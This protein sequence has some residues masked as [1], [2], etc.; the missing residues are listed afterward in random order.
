MLEL[1]NKLKVL[2][3]NN[4]L[5]QAYMANLL[6]IT[7]R[8]YQDIEYG[9]IDL[10]LSK[11]IKLADFFNVSLDYLVG[12]SNEEAVK[13]SPEYISKLPAQT[14]NQENKK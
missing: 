10:P 9:K 3:K 5:T 8:H 13:I 2:R 4:K 7:S 1:G 12:R 6:N 11:A 14:S